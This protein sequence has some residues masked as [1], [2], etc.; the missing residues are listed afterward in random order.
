MAK[1]GTK[2]SNNSILTDDE[3]IISGRE[4][5]E[6]MIKNEKISSEFKILEEMYQDALFDMKVLEQKN[7]V[8]S[9]KYQ[10]LKSKVD[11]LTAKLNQ[12]TREEEHRKKFEGGSMVLEIKADRNKALKNADDRFKKEGTKIMDDFM[13]QFE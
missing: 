10:E 4:I 12:K 1:V 2:K 3:Y 11:E 5:K 8:Y 13:K 6:N 9:K 7:D